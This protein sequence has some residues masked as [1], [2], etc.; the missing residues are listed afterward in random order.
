MSPEDIKGLLYV[1]L[2]S[3]AHISHP[4]IYTISLPK[5][6]YR[7]RHHPT[8][9]EN[10]HIPHSGS[11]FKNPSTKYLTIRQATTENHTST[12]TRTKTAQQS[13]MLFRNP[14]GGNV[15][16]A[17]ETNAR[18]FAPPVTSLA[19]QIY[20]ES[21][22]AARGQP[23]AKGYLLKARMRRVSEHVAELL[24]QTYHSCHSRPSLKST[25]ASFIVAELSGESYFAAPV[26]LSGVS[27][28][29]PY[30]QS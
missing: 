4:F 13:P 2:F 20:H 19:P 5:T 15:L 12:V 14:T 16:P 30:L 24:L 21:H 18:F 27:G 22:P 28:Y 1:A 23:T 9:H 3:H 11:E 26:E 17:G 7:H 6:D 10:V 29:V 8:C 25:A